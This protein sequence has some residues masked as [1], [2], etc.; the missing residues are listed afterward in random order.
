MSTPEFGSGRFLLAMLGIEPSALSML[1][2]GFTAEKTSR[3]IP[4]ASSSSLPH[5]LPPQY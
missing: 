3:A 2:K 4:E 1:T 5:P